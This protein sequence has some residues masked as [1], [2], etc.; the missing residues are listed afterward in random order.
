M[1]ARRVD[2]V[3]RRVDG[4]DVRMHPGKVRDTVPIFGKLTD[5]LLDERA[6]L[7]PAPAV[8]RDLIHHDRP[9]FHCHASGSIISRPH[10]KQWL[11]ERMATWEARTLVLLFASPHFHASLAS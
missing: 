5:W 9:G 11:N 8:S 1:P 7:P 2:F 3:V 10:I 6:P 4:T